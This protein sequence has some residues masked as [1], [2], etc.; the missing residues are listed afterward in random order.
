MDALALVVCQFRQRKH[1]LTAVGTRTVG[2]V[3]R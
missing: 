3:G 2:N 1:E